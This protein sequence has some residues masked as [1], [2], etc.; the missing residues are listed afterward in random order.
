MLESIHS[1]TPESMRFTL[2]EMSDKL[3]MVIEMAF[4]S[5]ILLWSKSKGSEL[6][7]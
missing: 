1:I 6:Q 5:T 3:F 7:I 2:E 4:K